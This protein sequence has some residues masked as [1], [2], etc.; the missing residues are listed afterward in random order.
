MMSE[1]KTLNA[2]ALVAALCVA[3]GCVADSPSP[4]VPLRVMTYNIRNSEGDRASPDNNWEGRRGDMANLVARAAPDIV[5]FQ[6]VL[7]DQKEFLERRFP[8]YRFV[9]AF[10]NADGRTGEASPIAYRGARFDVVAHGTFWLSQTPDV[11]GSLSWGA[12]IPRV[13]SWA[14]LVDKLCGQRFAFANTHTD[15][16]SEE[17]REKGML[18]VIDRMK[19]FGENSPIVFVGDHNCLGVDKPAQA[20]SKMLRDAMF[21]SETPPEG[22]WR[23]VNGWR[24]RDNETTIAEA[25]EMSAEARNSVY[26]RSGDNRID[27]IYVSADIQVHACRTLADPRPGKK[28]YPSDHFPV[29]ADVEFA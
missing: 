16:L 27:Y 6:E 14:V 7:P 10:R 15:H 24:W 29:V 1:K 21:V 25:M 13:C 3:T 22:P 11:P 18:L 8:E 17:A 20:V 2:N 4:R 23:T 19:K 9:G 12:T 28:L 5:G 26:P